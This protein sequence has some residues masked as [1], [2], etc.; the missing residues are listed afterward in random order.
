MGR[1][2]VKQFSGHGMAV[3]LMSSQLT[4]PIQDGAPINIPSRIGEG[5]M[6]PPPLHEEL[7][8]IRGC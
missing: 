6:R 8:T 4:V 5:L 7:L 3:V 1:S 2:A